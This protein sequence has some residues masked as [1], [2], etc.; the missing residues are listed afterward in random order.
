M[1]FSFLSVPPFIQLSSGHNY[2]E[3]TFQVQLEKVS[4][5]EKKL[6]K[7]KFQFV[8]EKLFANLAPLKSLH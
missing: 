2:S 7:T 8:S 6:L 1:A 3:R 4:E 5:L